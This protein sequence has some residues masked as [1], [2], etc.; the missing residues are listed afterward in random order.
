M[1]LS[2][3]SMF[4]AVAIPL[5]AAEPEPLEIEVTHK[6][7]C[8]RKT[9]KGDRIDVHYS[10]TLTSGKKFDASYDRNDPLTFVVGRGDV[11]KGWDEGLLDMCEGEHRKLTVQPIY[12]YGMRSVG[13]IPANS[14]LIFETELVKIHEEHGEL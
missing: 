8:D 3:I 11:I 6:V 1:R 9:K 5:V 10:G 13:P 2:F 4:L 14:I 12:G 7:E